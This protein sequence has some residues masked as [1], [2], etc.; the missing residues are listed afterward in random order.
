MKR[1]AA[2][3]LIVTATG[4]LTA[5]A[6]TA[7]A[8]SK[9]AGKAPAGA[10]RLIRTAKVGGDG[11]FDYVYADVSGRRL[12]IPRS[13]PTARISVYN[14]DTLAPVGDIP[15]ASAHGVAID[16]KSG[17]AFATSKPVVMWEAHSLAVIKTI[18]VTGNPDGILADPFNHRIYVFSHVAPN[19][20]VIDAADGTVLGT[21]DLGGAPEQAV[22]D[23]KGHLYVD[24]ED[25]DQVA[26]VDAKAMRVTAH[27]SLNGK[28]GGPA[29]LAFDARNRIL[30][31]ACHDP[32]N[33]AVLQADTGKIL[34]V[35]PIGTGV[36]GATFNP[37]TMEVFSSQGDGSL[38]VV[39][40]ASPTS[41]KLEQTVA[42]RTGAKA[43]T[44]DTRTN[45]VLLT[46]AEFAPP[47]PG[48]PAPKGPPGRPRRG[49][50]IPGSFSILVV[51]R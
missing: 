30:F 45:H 33:M 46:T 20:T 43:L 27:Y 22:T 4:L 39:K 51:G 32:A 48:A 21:L 8:A 18:A 44:L 7:P 17:H 35:V 9:S 2:T 11:G 41:F 5:G 29:G 12:Y 6:L 16:A 24:L 34:D 19:A 13:G 1:V 23:G 28:C 15:K 3:C 38:T 14:L 10:Y 42:T 26:V 36:D 31:A 49:P 47:A 50:M 40:E 37:N 25:K